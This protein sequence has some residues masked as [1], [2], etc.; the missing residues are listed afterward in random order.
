[1]VES[2]K[3]KKTQRKFTSSHYLKPRQG[4][5]NKIKKRSRYNRMNSNEHF[6]SNKGGIAKLCK[7]CFLSDYLPRPHDDEMDTRSYIRGTKQIDFVFCSFNIL[8]TNHYI[9]GHDSKRSQLKTIE[10]YL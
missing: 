6:Q 9:E 7:T 2:L 8:Q 1:M 10:V 3:A 4:N 5:T